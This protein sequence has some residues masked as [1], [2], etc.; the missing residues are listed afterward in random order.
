MNGFRLA[1]TNISIFGCLALFSVDVVL[2][3]A[4]VLNLTNHPPRMHNTQLPTHL[5]ST[6]QQS[7]SRGQ[8][9][10]VACNI[11]SI[12]NTI[13]QRYIITAM[14]RSVC[15]LRLGTRFPP[16]IHSHRTFW[17]TACP[18]QVLT[19]HSALENASAALI[20]RYLL[21]FHL[22]SDNCRWIH[23]KLH[24]TT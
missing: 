7:A 22:T 8:S 14:F 11:Y 18:R 4:A 16:K 24:H 1:I 23:Q 13:K 9:T 10:S 3:Q 5:D 2:A 19:N 17:P 21:L 6:R 20:N 15:D 12:R